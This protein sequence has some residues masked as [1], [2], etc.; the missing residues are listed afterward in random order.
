[1]GLAIPPYLTAIRF[2]RSINYDSKG[3]KGQ[4]EGDSD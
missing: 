3:V 4:N 1:M 2:D